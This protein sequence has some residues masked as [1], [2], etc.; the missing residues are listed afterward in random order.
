MH[1][2]NQQVHVRI[3]TS[4]ALDSV[5]FNNKPSTTFLKK[6]LISLNRKRLD[7]KD[8]FSVQYSLWRSGECIHSPGQVLGI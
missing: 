8:Y 6:D 4:I 1:I 2:Y 5:V 7:F 3:N